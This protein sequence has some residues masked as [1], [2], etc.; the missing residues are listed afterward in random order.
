MCLAKTK[1]DVHIQQPYC[2]GEQDEHNL[3]HPGANV[4]NSLYF[5]RKDGTLRNALG[6]V[7]TEEVTK[8]DREATAYGKKQIVRSKDLVVMVG[9]GGAGETRGADEKFTKKLDWAAGIIGR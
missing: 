4:F 1:L 3:A 8:G 5:R 6:G 9:T 2:A 7:I